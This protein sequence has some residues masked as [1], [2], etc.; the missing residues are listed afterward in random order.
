MENYHHFK[1]DVF[2]RFAKWTSSFLGQPKAFAMAVLIIAGWALVGPI[3][4]FSDTWQLIINTS[5]TIVT[6]LMVFVIQNSQNRDSAS[7]QIKLDELIRA[8][9]AAHNSLLDLE[10]LSQEQLE[11]MREHYSKLAGK[12]RDTLDKKLQEEDPFE[13]WDQ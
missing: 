4:H 12:A 9:D 7:I 1:K 5:T 6:F 13:T 3:F 2:S 10:N 8:V 11:K